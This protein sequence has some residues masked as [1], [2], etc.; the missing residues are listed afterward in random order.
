MPLHE[1]STAEA[2]ALF[3]GRRDGVTCSVGQGHGGR[4]TPTIAVRDVQHLALGG[5]RSASQ[6]RGR[7]GS[8]AAELAP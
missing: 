2:S 8:P 4:P 5:P 3:F 6:L 7:G 1:H